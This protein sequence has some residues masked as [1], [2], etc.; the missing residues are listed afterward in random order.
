M[1]R[2]QGPGTRGEAIPPPR[3]RFRARDVGRRH[4][5]PAATDTGVHESGEDVRFRN[6]TKELRLLCR[7]L[8]DHI[9]AS[10]TLASGLT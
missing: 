2:G 9:P 5:Q 6:S 8:R 1:R 10:I 4:P 7:H 3:A